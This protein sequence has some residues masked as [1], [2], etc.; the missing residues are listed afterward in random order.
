MTNRP[1]D[2][3][4]GKVVAK[5]KP[6]VGYEGIYQVSDCGMVRSIDRRIINSLGHHRFYEGK[7]I[8]Q[9]IRNGYPVVDLWNQRPKTHSVH[10]LVAQAFVPNPDNLPEV[11][12]IDGN[13]S[14]RHYANLEWISRS[15]NAAH[16][17]K[18]GIMKPSQMPMESNGNAKL[19]LAQVDEI[20]ALSKQGMSSYKI[21]ERYGV[22]AATVQR[23]VN[24]ASWRK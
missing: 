2:E 11:N 22:H 5:W 13:K 10:R 17:Y 20:R 7:M 19:T 3:V 9:R 18:T 1:S 15:G 16:A 8:K 12:H 21:A 4:A 14:N 23:A 6:V 24:G